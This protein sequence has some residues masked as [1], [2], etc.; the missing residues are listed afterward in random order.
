M[1]TMMTMTMTMGEMQWEYRTQLRHGF[2]PRTM[3]AWAVQPIHPP[4]YTLNCTVYMYI[5]QSEYTCIYAAHKLPGR[6]RGGDFRHAHDR[7]ILSNTI[8][9]IVIFSPK[10]IIV[11]KLNTPLSVIWSIV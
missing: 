6:G 9:I 2:D 8:V 4:V 5:A 1:A 10:S 3:A 11:I 7:I